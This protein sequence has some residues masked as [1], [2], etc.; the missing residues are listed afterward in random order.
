M[1]STK[2]LRELKCADNIEAARNSCEDAFFLRQAASHVAGFPLINATHLIIES[3]IE[4]RWSKPDPN[5]L[6]MMGS[7]FA[8]REKCSTRWF[9]RDNPCRDARLAQGS[10]HSHE[11]PCRSHRPAK[12][13]NWPF[14]LFQ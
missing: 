7:C 2:F 11:H 1:P 12:S 8:S 14:N 3:G 4:E 6:D 9:Q 10:G 13:V 5:A